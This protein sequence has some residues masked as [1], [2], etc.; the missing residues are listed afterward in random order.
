[1]NIL[2]FD[3]GIKNLAYCLV[4][5]TN[6]SEK[7]F[8]IQDWGVINLMSKGG[9]DHET[10]TCITC[11][12]KA[13]LQTMSG[14]RHYCA[15]HAKKDPH[16]KP[17]DNKFKEFAVVHSLDK[18]PVKRLNEFIEHNSIIIAGKKP[19]KGELLEMVKKFIADWRLVRCGSGEKKKKANDF[20][21]VK[22]G[23]SLRDKLDLTFSPEIRSTIDKIVIENQI[24]PLAIRMKS[25]QGMITQ[26]F[27][28][29]G[30]E[31]ISYISA[32]NKLKMFEG[33]EIMYEAD[34][35]EE[36]SDTGNKKKYKERKDKSVEI[37]EKLVNGTPKW[38]DVYNTHS[39]KDDLA[40]SLLQ[41]LWYASTK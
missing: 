1:M 18:I 12:K 23:I 31:D 20:D 5:V 41:A 40:D 4:N 34:S 14:D 37:V 22:L 16:F 35:D 21:L 13:T 17:I 15:I 25:L 33:S 2:S 38:G 24:G 3:V 9:D 28:M 19:L 39:K 11:K 10:A 30:V 6:A 29:K 8:D 26:Y 7:Q 36:V 32:T 27:I